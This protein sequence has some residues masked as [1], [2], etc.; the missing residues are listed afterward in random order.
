MVFTESSAI[1]SATDFE[2]STATAGVAN[3]RSSNISYFS[4]SSL[5]RTVMQASFSRRCVNGNQRMVQITLKAVCTMAIQN[6]SIFI[7]SR[8]LRL[9]AALTIVNTVSKTTE[10]ITLKYR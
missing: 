6:S 7:V 8:K 10:P 1:D 3:R 2:R 5:S 9:S 4:F